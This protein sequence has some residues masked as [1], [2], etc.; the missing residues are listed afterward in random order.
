MLTDVCIPVL[1]QRLYYI[2]PNNGL[3]EIDLSG[4]FFSN[5]GFWELFMGY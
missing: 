5:K 1:L 3:S 4:N 2:R